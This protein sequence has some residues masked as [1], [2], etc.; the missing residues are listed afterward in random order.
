[1][2]Y[3]QWAL[4]RVLAYLNT[5][6]S[7]E[8]LLAHPDLKDD[9]ANGSGYIIGKKVA[10]NIIN[11]KRS[12]P[13][14][15]YQSAEDILSVSGLGQDKLNDLLNSF[16]TSAD[17]AFVNR[18]RDGILYDN[19]ELHPQSIEFA[20]LAEMQ[21]VTQGLDRLRRSVAEVL[22]PTYRWFDR[23]AQ[24]QLSLRIRQ[25]YVAGYP[26]S[27]LAAFQFAYWWY[28]FDQDNWFSYDRIKEACELYLSYHGS[29]NPGMEF[30]LLHLYSDRPNNEVSRSELIPVVINYPELKITVWVVELND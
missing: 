30:A 5:A 7:A 6:R 25:A 22:V 16:N 2:D 20:T 26:E 15:R 4:A 10:D 12:L 28:L 8:E 21:V 19:W 14:R 18:L 9:P 23:N 27:H 11:Q 1:M 29:V 3:P 13:R 24:R 17:T